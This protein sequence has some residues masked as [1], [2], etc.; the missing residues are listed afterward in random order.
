MHSLPLYLSF[1]H[2]LLTQAVTETPQPYAATDYFL[3]NCGSS[4]DSTSLDGRNWEGDF[5]SKFSPPNIET[6]SI[7]STPSQHDP[8]VTQVPYTSARIFH[9]KFTYSF[10]VSP[11]LKFVR[12][13]FFPA[14]Y[15][16]LHKSKSFS[17]VT[18]NNFTLL[19]NFSAF[20]T[21]SSI[22][23]PVASLSKNS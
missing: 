10:P 14:T 13:Y 21:V 3:L 4:S 16:G 17:F 15:S 22:E 5:N 9:N 1:L 23:P 6:T 7:A 11:G 12:L 18:A 19:S 20:L 2:L 8:S